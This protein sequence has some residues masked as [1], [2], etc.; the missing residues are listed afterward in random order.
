MLCQSHNPYSVLFETISFDNVQKIGELITLKT[1]RGC[2]S[3]SKYAS[4]LYRNYV[5][6]LNRKNQ[7]NY[8]LSDAYDL[9]QIAIC[10]LYQFIG[11]QLDDVYQVKNGKIITIR[12]ATYSLVSRHIQRNYKSLMRSCNIDLYA[13]ILSVEIEDYQEKDYTE[14][15][16]TISRLGLTTVEQETLNC[17]MGGMSCK[18]IAE[19]LAIDRIT[20]WRRRQ[21]VQV[22]Y[23]SL[24]H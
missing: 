19:F 23:K 18:E 1:L 10:F 6:D 5:N 12:K 11:K 22:K 20:V 21:R 16:N 24:F 7:A 4:V 17:Y 15:D 2:S 3:Y 14:V 8:V 9:A 13:E